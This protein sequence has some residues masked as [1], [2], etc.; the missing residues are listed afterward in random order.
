MIV[1]LYAVKDELS[2]EFFAP[3]II[4]NDDM[5]KRQFKSQINTIPLWKDNP[6]DYSLYRIGTFDDEKG[7]IT[8]DLEKMIGGR[9]VV[10][11]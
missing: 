5:A 9:S 2:N 4:K 6:S 10:D 3:Q 8:S 7:L 1:H 11:A